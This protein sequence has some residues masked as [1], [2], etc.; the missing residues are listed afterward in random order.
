MEVTSVPDVNRKYEYKQ[1]FKEIRAEG[2]Q[3]EDI[4]RKLGTSTSYAYQ[5]ARGERCGEAIM[6]SLMTTWCSEVLA[7]AVGLISYQRA[8]PLG[9]G[10]TNADV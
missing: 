4:G 9:E 6:G 5:L 8:R 7:G 10:H 2:L 1:A 3:M